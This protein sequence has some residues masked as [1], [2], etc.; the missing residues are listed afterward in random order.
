M[1][2]CSCLTQL[3]LTE[4]NSYVLTEEEVFEWQ[5]IREILDSVKIWRHQRNARSVIVQTV[6]R[7]CH[8]QCRKCRYAILTLAWTR[9]KDHMHKTLNRG[10]TF[11]GMITKCLF[12]Q[13]GMECYN[14]NFVEFKKIY[15]QINL[16]VDLVRKYSSKS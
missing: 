13:W 2:Q 6:Q 15:L 16:W 4:I 5:K 11:K 9:K 3:T 14:I 7:R 12:K 8:F 1:M 10:V